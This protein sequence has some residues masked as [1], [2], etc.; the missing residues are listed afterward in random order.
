MR[1]FDRICDTPIFV[2]C[3]FHC[4]FVLIGTLPIATIEE[5]FAAKH[6]EHDDARRNFDA[7][8]CVRR[9]FV[10][11]DSSD[12]ARVAR[13]RFERVNVAIFGHI[14]GCVACYRRK[15]GDRKTCERV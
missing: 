8:F 6:Y 11:A 13:R 4:S 14:A 2:E 7:M 9:R 5:P 12:S 10:A 1:I 15:I 3:F